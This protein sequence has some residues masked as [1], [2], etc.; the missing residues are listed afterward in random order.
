MGKNNNNAGM[1]FVRHSKKVKYD[2]LAYYDKNS[3]QGIAN[4]RYQAM[5]NLEEMGE[6]LFTRYVSDIQIFI[7][8]REFDFPK[9]YRVLIYNKE[10]EKELKFV[11]TIKTLYNPDKTDIQAI[12]VREH[13]K[14]HI[15]YIDTELYE[16]NKHLI[17]KDTVYK[18]K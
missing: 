10:Y 18:L 9:S 14:Q 12:R 7:G 2:N 17:N 6:Y 4:R 5:A 1:H 16:K 11:S 3:E 13:D 8:E 15:I